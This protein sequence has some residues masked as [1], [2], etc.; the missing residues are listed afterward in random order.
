RTK[1]RYRTNKQDLD[2]KEEQAAV[3]SPVQNIGETQRLVSAIAGV[4]LLAAA[5]SRRTWARM[6]F[7]L[8][9]TGLLFRAASGYCPAS[10]AMGIS[11]Q[12]VRDTNRIGRRKVATQQAAK[13]RRSV[14][15]NRPPHE[16]YR[17][18]R[19]LDNL[20]RVMSHL[21]SVEVI[22]DRLSHWIVK[23]LPGIPAVE[24]DAEIIN[25][26]ENERIGWRSLHGADVDNTGSVEF[27]PAG[28]GQRTK[29][30]VTL[31]YAPPAGR[32]GT[33]VAK[34]VGEDAGSKISE[35]LQRFKETIEAGLQPGAV[36]R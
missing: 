36:G 32:F 14:E 24:W 1:H 10:S 20:P 30:T 35:D 19:S 8:V 3:S 26:V 33:A 6:A 23:T 28:N 12:D 4:G 7:T 13:I 5:L 17:F 9:G 16:L 15:I 21:Q 25:E 11:A 27:E 34:L 18:W 29:L 31:Q 2:W 22:N